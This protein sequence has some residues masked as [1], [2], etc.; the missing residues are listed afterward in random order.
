MEAFLSAVCRCF[1]GKA[2]SGDRR[3]A[4]TEIENCEQFL[5]FEFEFH[6]PELVIPV[7]KMAIDRFIDDKKYKLEDVIG[8]EFLGSKYGVEFKWIPLPHPSGMN[9][10]NQ[11]ETGKKLI[12]RSLQLLKKNPV[13]QEEFFSRKL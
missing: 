8:R 11:T 3:P 7:G 2:G 12:E 9:V 4:K 10:W 5:R 13:I 1:P 6:K